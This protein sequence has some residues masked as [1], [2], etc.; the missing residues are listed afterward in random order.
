MNFTYSKWNLSLQDKLL[1]KVLEKLFQ[2]FLILKTFV[3]NLPKCFTVGAA[4]AV[5]QYT[6]RQTRP[7]HVCHT[8][9][10]PS[11]SAVLKEDIL[12]TL[13][14]TEKV[15]IPYLCCSTRR[16]D[17]CGRPYNTV[18]LK[19]TI[20]NTCHPDH[21]PCHH[22]H[23]PVITTTPLSSRPHHLSS[24]AQSRDLCFWLGGHGDPPLRLSFPTEKWRKNH[25][26]GKN[27]RHAIH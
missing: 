14:V 4:L 22:D 3:I 1:K 20:H 18:L 2:N 6:G 12:A 23:T 9:A 21:I 24:R 10:Q 26:D 27:C 7:L 25:T 8:E 15:V 16:G 5:A 19:K 17:P 11:V 13:D